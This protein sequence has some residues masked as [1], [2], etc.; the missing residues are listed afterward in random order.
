LANLKGA[1]IIRLHFEHTVT[2]QAVELLET[3][4]VTPEELLTIDF[5]EADV[6]DGP[7]MAA[8]ISAVK[9]LLEKGQPLELHQPPQMVVHNLYRV[10]YHPH[11][12]LSVQDM[13]Q[14]EAY[15]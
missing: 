7:N 14:D 8:L 6:E 1:T 5:S 10:G 15:G 3:L 12:L 2:L 9:L 11:P 4:P 13:R